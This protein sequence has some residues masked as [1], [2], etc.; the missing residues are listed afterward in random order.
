MQFRALS[1]LDT[2][3]TSVCD[4]SMEIDDPLPK[5]LALLCSYYP[6]IAEVCRKLDINRQQFNKYLAGHARPS[7]HNFR[8]VCDFFGVTEAELLLEPHRFEELLTIRRKPVD[9]GEMAEP[10]RH[11]DRLYRASAP[12]DRYIG[13]YYR[14]FYSFGYPGKIIKSFC[15]IYEKDGKYFWK[16]MEV[17]RA[18][19][20]GHSTSVSKYLGCALLLSDRIHIM[21]YGS[22]VCNSITQ[23]TLYPS[24]HTRVD[25]LLGIHT[26]GAV[27][28]GR[29]PAAS[30]VVLEYLGRDVDIRRALAQA[31]IFDEG[32][33]RLPK[34]IIALIRNDI[35]EGNYVL[36]VEEP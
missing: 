26:G 4:T 20:T 9:F 31:D 25:Y 23:M 11:L 28:R 2:D 8:R 5:N 36:D 27:R 16:N 12:M 6:S 14:Y 1:R 15:V 34:D 21:E 7:R 24:Y 10:L 35:T 17:M 32:D 13:Y 30:R 22:M 33:E 29:R 18:H 3:A 19:T